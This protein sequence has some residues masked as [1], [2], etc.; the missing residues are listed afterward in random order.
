MTDSLLC[1]VKSSLMLRPTVSRPVGQS[2]SRPVC[3]GIKHPS[4][5]YDQIFYFCQTVAGLLIRG[6]LSDERM[7]LSFTIAAGLRQRSHSRIRVPWDSRPYFTVSDSRLPFSSHPTTRRITVEV[8]YPAST[9]EFA[10]SCRF[11]SCDNFGRTV[12][13]SPPS[14]VPVLL[15]TSALCWISCINSGQR[16]DS[17]VCFRETCFKNSLPSNGLFRVATGMYSA[18]PRPAGSHIAAFRRHVAICIQVIF[19]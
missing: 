14:R 10:L 5:A 4:G 7:G 12:W 17:C 15:F 9:R 19:S 11:L 16:F 18:K 1:R 6:A 3:L 8:F 13:K 2:A